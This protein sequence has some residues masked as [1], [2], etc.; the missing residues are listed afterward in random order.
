MSAL[1][2]GHRMLASIVAIT[3]LGIASTSANALPLN[4]AVSSAKISDKN[5][6]FLLNVGRRYYY[7]DDYYYAYRPYRYYRYRPYRSYGYVYSARPYYYDDYYYRPY[8][9]RPYR[10][11][12]Y[13]RAPFVDLYI[14]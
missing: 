9:G 2:P 12:L 10:G 3:M 14:P 1:I 7:D 11:G 6:G 4:S 5:N 8:V 13:I